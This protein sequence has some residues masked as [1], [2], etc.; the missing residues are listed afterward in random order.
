MGQGA[1]HTLPPLLLGG[2][3]VFASA[4]SRQGTELCLA[5][6]LLRA[7]GRLDPRRGAL[8]D[9]GDPTLRRSAL[10]RPV[11]FLG[12]TQGP[13]LSF[14]HGGGRIW[15]AMSA[16]GGVGIDLAG[17]EEFPDDYPFARAFRKEELECAGALCGYDRAR[18]AALMWAVKE[19]AV[20]AT[21]AGFNFLDPRDVR[22]GA[23]L[24]GEQGIL[25]EVLAD[26]PIAAW[27]RSEGKGWLSVALAGH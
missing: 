6:V 18:G 7:L 10:G 8:P 26:R 12:E 4:E 14:S 2:A 22:V 5:S 24:A 20:K 9:E 1:I 19:S 25:L 27:A 3:V 23:P 21:G 15:A 11:L 17:P 13:A 16:G